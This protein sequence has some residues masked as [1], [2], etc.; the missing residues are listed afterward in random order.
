M[1]YAAF[2]MAF[3]APAIALAVVLRRSPRAGVGAPRA[4][5]AIPL[6][7][8]I[9]LFFTT[10][11]DNYIVREGVW[12]YGADR[13]LAVVGYVPVE[14]YAFFLLQPLLAGLWLYRVL[15]R[16]PYRGET[17]SERVRWLGVAVWTGVSAAGV[18]LLVGDRSGFYLGM[19][20]AAFG[21]VLTGLWLYGGPHFAALTGRWLPVV[22]IVGT[23]L[24]IADRIAIGE[25]IWHIAEATSTGVLV[26][27]LPIEEAVFFYVTTLLSVWSVLLFLHGDRIPPFWRR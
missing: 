11:W 8:L 4:T 13:V 6:T 9:A 19:I 17:S 7:C 2:L 22:L 25:G 10:P 20:L 27:G 16:R 1:T 3:V 24:S 5:W 26:A 23:Y 21:P 12:S 14:E 18:A 15:E